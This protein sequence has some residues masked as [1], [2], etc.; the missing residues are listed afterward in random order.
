M[1]HLKVSLLAY[2]LSTTKKKKTLLKEL[3]QKLRKGK[4]VVFFQ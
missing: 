3:L 2:T 4:N 1:H